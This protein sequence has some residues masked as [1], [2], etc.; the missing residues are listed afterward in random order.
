MRDA[1]GIVEEELHPPV[2]LLAVRLDEDVAD[3][4]LGV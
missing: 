1:V 2:R 4:E 3:G